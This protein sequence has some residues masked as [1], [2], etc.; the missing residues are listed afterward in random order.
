MIYCLRFSF[1]FLPETDEA[2]VLRSKAKCFATESLNER[3]NDVLKI[4][5]NFFHFCSQLFVPISFSLLYSVSH[6]DKNLDCK[7]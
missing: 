3:I 7:L 1:F 5:M 6:L 4:K 2:S